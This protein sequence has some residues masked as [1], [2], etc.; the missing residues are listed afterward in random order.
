MAIVEEVNLLWSDIEFINTKD[1]GDVFGLEDTSTTISRD[2]PLK[3]SKHCT[4]EKNRIVRF[5][6]VLILTHDIQSAVFW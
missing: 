6:T 2:R 3:S 4:L 1:L 5:L